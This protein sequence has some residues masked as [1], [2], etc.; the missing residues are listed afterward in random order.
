MSGAQE[1]RPMTIAPVHVARL[2]A[3][4]AEWEQALAACDFDGTA[5]AGSRLVGTVEALLARHDTGGSS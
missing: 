4:V 1:E 3:L 2:R 5:N